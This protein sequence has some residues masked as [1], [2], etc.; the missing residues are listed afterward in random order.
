MCYY[1]GR[2]VTKSYTKA[3]EWLTKAAN[4]GDAIAQYYLGQCYQYGRGVRKNNQEAYEWYCISAAQGYHP[5]QEAVENI[6]MEM[7]RTRR[8]RR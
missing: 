5:A 3:V 7:A 8:H 6:D 4:Q 2:G 1:T